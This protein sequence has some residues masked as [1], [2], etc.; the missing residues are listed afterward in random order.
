MPIV[1]KAK[2][3]D[4][5]SIVKI[6]LDGIGERLAAYTIYSAQGVTAY[7]RAQIKSCNLGTSCFFVSENDSGII[8]FAEFKFFG[9]EIFLNN[10]YVSE[11]G[12]GAGIGKVLLNAG[13]VMAQ[14]KNMCEIVLDVFKHNINALNW[15]RKLGFKSREEFSW[16]VIDQN[17]SR[18]SK[19]FKILNL[20]FAEC[21]CSEFGFATLD[22]STEL[23][24]YSVGILNDNFYRVT[25]PE[26]LQDQTLLAGLKLLDSSKKILFIG[27]DSSLP[28]LEENSYVK[29]A[30]CL[31]M[32]A[33]VDGVIAYLN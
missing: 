27:N 31:R 22:I 2:Q 1:R 21:V 8:G 14:E 10:I 26:V 16:L 32:A 3:E 6:L 30:T 13:L 11:Q 7:V 20:P 29:V 18:D 33:N 9:S 5:E 28:D 24:S 25:S 15:Y 17:P 23:D 19:W 4:S 12:R